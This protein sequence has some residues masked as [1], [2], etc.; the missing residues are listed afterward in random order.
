METVIQPLTNDRSE[1]EQVINK[2]KR[3]NNVAVNSAASQSG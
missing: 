2:I 3:L 1:T